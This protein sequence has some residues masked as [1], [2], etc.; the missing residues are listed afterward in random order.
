[1]P[2]KVALKNHIARLEQ[3]FI[4]KLQNFYKEILGFMRALG[5]VI[6]FQTDAFSLPP[7]TSRNENKILLFVLH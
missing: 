1:M 4:A 3:R 2:K 7:L 5:L 6:S